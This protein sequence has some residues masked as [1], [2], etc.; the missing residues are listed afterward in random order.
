[1]YFTYVAWTTTFHIWT[2]D[3]QAHL[4]PRG[5]LS[6]KCW[7]SIDLTC[8]FYSTN[9][10]LT[11]R[12]KYI[13]HHELSTSILQVKST[14]CNQLRALDWSS[15]EWEI[16]YHKSWTASWGIGAR[17]LHF[18]QKITIQLGNNPVEFICGPELVRFDMQLDSSFAAAIISQRPSW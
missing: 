14:F 11:L 7:K 12:I 1:M 8:K 5:N 13:K 2:N 15:W 18:S 3:I 10:M 4:D 6:M 16:V 17:K 9:T